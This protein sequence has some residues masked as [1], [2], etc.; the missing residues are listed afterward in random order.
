MSELQTSPLGNENDVLE[1]TDDFDP[2]NTH[3]VS[4]KQYTDKRMLDNNHNG[5]GTLPEP[6]MEMPPDLD[7][8]IPGTGPANKAGAQPGPKKPP[9]RPYEPAMNPQMDEL[10]KA[11]KRKAAEQA[12]DAMI[13]GYAYLIGHAHKLAI[14]SVRTL[15]KMEKKG[16][17]ISK[18][19]VIP[20]SRGQNAPLINVV[21]QWNY[22][23]KSKFSVSNEFRENI[24][25]PLVRILERKGIGLSDEGVC[26]YELAK[27]L[28][29]QG[30]NL[31]EARD[32]R[33]EFID[34][35]KELNQTLKNNGAY[36]QANAPTPPPPQQQ[37]A[38]NNVQAEPA[39]KEPVYSAGPSASNQDQSKVMYA[40]PEEMR[41]PGN[42]NTTPV[43]PEPNAGNEETV[44]A[45]VTDG[46]NGQGGQLIVIEEKPKK[47]PGKKGSRKIK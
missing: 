45:E 44:E 3:R 20:Y 38:A 13:G 24:K 22:A 7:D 27:E 34:Q 37:A 31:K 29:N 33:R 9:P 28:I 19:M 32:D 17:I 43:A 47:R 14:I 40:E 8:D 15:D 42:N 18:D 23:I 36:Y 4:K 30:I 11:E 12:A 5:S 25:P 21:E 16:E 10:P 6:G 26:L 39:E 2:I 41:E 1:N 46:V 35:L